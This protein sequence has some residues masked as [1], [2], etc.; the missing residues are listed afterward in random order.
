MDGSLPEQDVFD[1]GRIRHLVELMKEHDLSEV[2]LRQGPMRIKLRRGHE[3]V[4]TGGELAPAGNTSG[5]APPAN[6]PVGQPAAAGGQ[7][8]A[9][10]KEHLAAISSPMVG[11]FYSAPDPDS[12]PF[13]KVGDHVGPETTVCI[14][15]AMKILNHIPAEVSGKIVSVLAQSGEPVEYGQRMFEVDTRA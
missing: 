6:H 11:T 5:A 13:V 9:I 3:P 2:D 14:V 12:P 10:S 4:V 15:E 1:L 7:P 8:A